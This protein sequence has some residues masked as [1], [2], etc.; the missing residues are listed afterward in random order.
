MARKRRSQKR[1]K[2]KSKPLQISISKKDLPSY[3]QK[4]GEGKSTRVRRA[5]TGI[6]Q[7]NGKKTNNTSMRMVFGKK[8]SSKKGKKCKK[9]KKKGCRKGK[10]NRKTRGKKVKK[11][12]DKRRGN[13]KSRSIKRRTKKNGRKMKGRQKKGA[14]KK[15]I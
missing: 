4:K 10:G 15:N 5:H 13:R 11:E 6:K 8:G 2:K 1:D 3:I 14:G 7:K 12:K 9:N